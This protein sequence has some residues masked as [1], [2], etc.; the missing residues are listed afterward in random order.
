MFDFHVH[1]SP[2]VVSRKCS[3]IDLAERYIAAN[4][5]HSGRLEAGYT[6]PNEKGIADDM[7]GTKTR[8]LLSNEHDTQEKGYY[9]AR[10]RE[11]AEMLKGSAP[12]NDT[13]SDIT[14]SCF[15]G[16]LIKCHYSDTAGRASLLNERY[17]NSGMKF[18]GGVVLNH[19]AGGI[20]HHAVEASAKMGGRIVWFPT[21][22]ARHYL[23]FR[24]L[25]S[26]EGIYILDEKGELIPEALKVLETAKK[27]G[28]LVA[29]GHI[30]SEEGMAL[31]R[32]GICKVI[33]THADN[34]ADFYT[35]E[36]QVEAVRLGALVEH[37]YYTILYKRTSVE[38]MTEQIR[39][40]G[41]E[42]VILSSDLGQPSSPYPDEG[43]RD[44]ASLMKAQG[45]GES[46]IRLMFHE[47]PAGLLDIS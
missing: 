12:E 2:D 19:S 37:S 1:T 15:T 31:V 21:M 45:F 22:D 41:I 3:D 9:I 30:S 10:R 20:N 4:G 18:F 14:P 13:L 36:Q 29:T 28:M 44:F 17:V 26:S 7:A 35:T 46:D 8:A 47:T 43:L 24:K 32:A 33:L 6:S 25:N 39:A 42:N 23:N 5:R 38:L 16:A 27:F 34:P 40:A 11:L